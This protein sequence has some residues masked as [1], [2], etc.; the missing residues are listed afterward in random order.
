MG[1][2]NGVARG[3]LMVHVDRV[4]VAAQPG[5]MDDVGFGDGAAERLPLLADFHVVEI[6]VLRGERHRLGPLALSPPPRL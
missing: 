1:R 2:R 3:E 5:E 4:E 6:E